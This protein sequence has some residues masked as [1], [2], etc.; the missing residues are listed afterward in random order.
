[1]KFTYG[2]FANRLTKMTLSGAEQLTKG[3]GW[4]VSKAIS[5]ET[6]QEKANQLANSIKKNSENISNKAGDIVDNTITGVGNVTG[7]VCKEAATVMGASQENIQKAEKIGNSVGKVATGCAVGVAATSVLISSLA[8]SG[9][10]GAASFSSGL[11]ALGGGSVATGGLGMVGGGVVATGIVAAS[12]IAAHNAKKPE[13]PPEIS[14]ET[15]EF[16]VDENE[17]EN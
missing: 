4:A 5:D 1:M 8:A 13:E 11:A 3:V 6:F 12:A 7:Y 2:Y 16:N 15:V 14:E 17:M 10:A 9:T